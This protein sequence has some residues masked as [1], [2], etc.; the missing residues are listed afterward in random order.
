[1]SD[2]AKEMP[3]EIWV[4]YKE[5]IPSAVEA[6]HQWPCVFHHKRDYSIKY[7]R[8]ATRPDLNRA[9]R[10]VTEKQLVDLV[11]SSRKFNTH[12]GEQTFRLATIKV[13]DFL[14]RDGLIKVKE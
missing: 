1:M 11:V 3:V 2:S 10:E 13:I 7:I 8:A 4:S 6:G 12:R 14:V 9:Q 5:H